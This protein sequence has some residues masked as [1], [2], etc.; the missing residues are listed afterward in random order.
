M[1]AL[2]ARERSTVNQFEG[3]WYSNKIGQLNDSFETVNVSAP[4]VCLEGFILCSC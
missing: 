2:K 4:N 1:A 3:A